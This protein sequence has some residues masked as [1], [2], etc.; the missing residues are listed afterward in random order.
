MRRKAQ[1]QKPRS[2]NATKPNQASAR[3]LGG[4][5]C[6]KARCRQATQ[7]ATPTVVV[8]PRAEPLRLQA[9]CESAVCDTP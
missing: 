8:V 2:R 6:P 9:I 3:E 7:Q 5:A 4:H 1:R